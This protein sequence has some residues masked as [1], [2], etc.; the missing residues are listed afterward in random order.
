[1]VVHG[2][3]GLDE[4]SLSAPTLVAEVEGGRVKTYRLRPEDVGLSRRP[5]EAIQGGD[6]KENA[7]ILRGVLSGEES[8]YLDVVLLNGGAA[9]YASGKTLTLREGVELARETIAAGKALSLLEDFIRL[10]Q[11]LHEK[12][13]VAS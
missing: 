13:E 2:E 6:A 10:T 12:G 8:P 3:D 5:P 1:L 9:L 7:R 4:V 11:K